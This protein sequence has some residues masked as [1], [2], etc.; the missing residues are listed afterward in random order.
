MLNNTDKVPAFVKLREIETI[1][2]NKNILCDKY[3][4]EN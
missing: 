2:N 4:A 3:Y 1:Q